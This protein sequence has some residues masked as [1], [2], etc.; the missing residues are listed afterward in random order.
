[1]NHTPLIMD[2]VAF[3]PTRNSSAASL[4]NISGVCV[5]DDSGFKSIKAIMAS[6]F[7]AIIVLEL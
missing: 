7:T 6:I 1:M 3:V 4:Y 2:F 5:F